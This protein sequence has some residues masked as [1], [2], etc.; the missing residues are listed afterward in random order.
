MEISLLY[1][2]LLL[3]Y[4]IILGHHVWK[5]HDYFTCNEM[6]TCFIYGVILGLIMLGLLDIGIFG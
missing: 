2:S 3:I 1:L 6:G 4:C 5:L